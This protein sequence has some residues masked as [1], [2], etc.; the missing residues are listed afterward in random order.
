MESVHRC[1]CGLIEQFL[2]LCWI[3]G[4]RDVYID[5]RMEMMN[6]LITSH[7]VSWFAQV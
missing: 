1:M 5:D 2:L 7:H 6:A 4:W 3:P